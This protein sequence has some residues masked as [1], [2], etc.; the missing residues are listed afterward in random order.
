MD[1]PDAREPPPSSVLRLCFL[2]LVAAARLR[3]IPS[4]PPSTLSGT[5]IAIYFD[6]DHV[7]ECYGCLL[8]KMRTKVCGL[9][10]LATA[11][12]SAGLRR[13]PCRRHWRSHST[14]RWPLSQRLRAVFLA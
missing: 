8:I 3:P 11:A 9:L 7:A 6:Y 13:A 10:A 12:S 5:A 14:A 4:T 1:G 2:H